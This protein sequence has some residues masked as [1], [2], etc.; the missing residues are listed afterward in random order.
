MTDRPPPFY[1]F[2]VT[3]IY[4][5]PAGAHVSFLIVATTTDG[6]RAAGDLLIAR[7]AVKATMLDLVSLGLVNGW[8]FHPTPPALR[9]PQSDPESPRVIT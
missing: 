6:A 9:R 2:Q 3:Y 7:M 8:G 4:D 1:V 5:H